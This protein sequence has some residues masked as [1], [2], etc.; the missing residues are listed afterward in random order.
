[1]SLPPYRKPGES[2]RLE[3]NYDL[4]ND[5]L[6]A[7]KWYKEYEEFYRYVPKDRPQ[8]SSHRVEGV[9]VDV[10]YTIILRLYLFNCFVLVRFLCLIVEKL[11][12]ER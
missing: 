8:A 2:A 7:V 9:H 3:C 5:T 4:G 6:Y 1:M 12:Y 10:I 11:S